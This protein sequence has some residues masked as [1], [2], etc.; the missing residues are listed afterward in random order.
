LCT[1]CCQCLW[2]VHSWLRLWFSVTLIL[3]PWPMT[4]LFGSYL[5]LRYLSYRL[6]I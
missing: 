3:V 2:I 1:Q 4:W 6:P 5:C